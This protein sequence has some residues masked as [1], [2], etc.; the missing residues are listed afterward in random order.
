MWPR[1]K[2]KKKKLRSLTRFHSANKL[3]TTTQQ[4]EKGGK[5][6]KKLQSLIGLLSVNKI[7]D[8]NRGGKGRGRKKSKSIY[9]TSQ[10]VRIINV[11]LESL[12]SE[13][14]PSLGVTVHLTSLGCPPTLLISGPAVGAAQILIWSYSCV[15]LPP[16]STAIR[17]SAF[18]FVRALSGLLYIP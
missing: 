9:R 11:F 3:T 13:S 7:D 16:M 4:G 5:K 1:E 8:Y 18:S 14:F 15:F 2:K 12:L 6:R 10:K 17:D